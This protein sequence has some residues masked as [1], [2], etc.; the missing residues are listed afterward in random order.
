MDAPIAQD[1]A[2][3][4]M[5]MIGVGAEISD[6]WRLEGSI[7]SPE[8]NV[9]ELELMIKYEGWIDGSASAGYNSGA[10]IAAIIRRSE[11][12]T[13]RILQI[14]PQRI[15]EEDLRGQSPLHLS[16]NWPRGVILLLHYGGREIL[17]R[18]DN[19]GFLPL[20]YSCTSQCLEAVKLMLD[21]DSALCSGRESPYYDNFLDP[22][23][24]FFHED[25]T[26]FPGVFDGAIMTGTDEIISHLETALVVRR[27]RLYTLATSEL[28]PKELEQLGVTSDRLLDEKACVVY[29]ALGRKNVPIP[30]ALRTPPD[31]TTLFHSEYLSPT[32]GESLYRRGF[33][34]LDCTSCFGLTPLMFL[35]HYELPNRLKAALQ[36]VSWLISRGADLGRKVNPPE[37][38]LFDPSITAA[39]C[40]G[41]WIGRA[42]YEA[43]SLDELEDESRSVLGK[44]AVLKHYDNCLCACSSHGCTP[45][46]MPLKGIMKMV[47]LSE[48]SSYCIEKRIWVIDWLN[49]LLGHSHEAWQWLSREIIRYVTFEKLGLAHTCCQSRYDV[50]DMWD[51]MDDK[52]REEIHDEER[53]SI[54]KLDALVTDF[55]EKYTELGVTVPEFLNGYWKTRMEEVERED[56][57]LDEEQIAKIKDL[58]VVIHS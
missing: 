8:S 12:D 13:E 54:R 30:S 39:H 48:V 55:E 29:A 44:M 18:P 28:T 32:L 26:N 45:A 1:R 3:L 21:A 50:F 51:D 46:I 24:G 33:I 52:E 56:E 5:E 34:D 19:E 7:S 53:L 36:R 2:Q 40:I 27:T 42:V 22:F 17:D 49:N 11:K 35:G 38:M 14:S 16:C 6:H 58:G 37:H 43:G 31:R 15:Y 25:I 23:R 47:R 9:K 4:A 20:A 41:S 57:P 10:L